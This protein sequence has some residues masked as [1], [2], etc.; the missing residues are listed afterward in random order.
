MIPGKSSWS[1]HK[2]SVSWHM[3]NGANRRRQ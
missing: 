3:S 2:G 1:V